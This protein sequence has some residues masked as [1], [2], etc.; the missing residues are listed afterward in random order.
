MGKIIRKNKKQIENVIEISK[1]NGRSSTTQDAI[2]EY[3]KNNPK[4]IRRD[5]YKLPFNEGDIRKCVL[6]ML[7]SH[8]I[9][10]SLTVM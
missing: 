6:I 5:L 2:Y 1:K 8:K 9:K 3:I 10:E 7:K 4:C